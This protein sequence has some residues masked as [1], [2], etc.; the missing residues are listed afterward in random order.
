M[1]K[2]T[3]E[4][5]VKWKGKTFPISFLSTATVEDLREHLYTETKIN[6]KHQ[7]LLGLKSNKNKKITNNLALKDLKIPKS[8]KV[9]LMGTPEKILQKVQEIPVDLPEI[10]DDLDF[11]YDNEE[12]QNIRTT[13]LEKKL[14]EFLENL[15]INIIN[16]PRAGKKLVVFDIDKTVFDMKGIG[17]SS[18]ELTRPGLHQML[19][20]LYPHYDIVFWSQTKWNW[21][22]AK[23]FEMGVLSN[24]KYGVNFVLDITSMFKITSDYYKKKASRSSKSLTKEEKKKLKKRKHWIKPLEI[25]WRKFPDFY[26][27]KNTIHIDDLGRNFVLNPKNG[28]LIKQFI[29]KAGVSKDKELLYLTEYLLYIANHYDDVRVLDHKRWKKEWARINRNRFE[30]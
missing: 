30:N 27:E 7:K 26:N 12:F 16:K 19:E 18:M 13:E 25:I 23:L 1:S 15:E 9:M 14:E 11:D 10:I 17:S 4:F 3:I 22:E 24:P 21:I 29:K 5:T 20:K 2:E 6:P 28:L 8:R